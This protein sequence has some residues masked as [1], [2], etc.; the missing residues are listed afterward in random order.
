MS[1]LIDRLEEQA[2]TI[3]GRLRHQ[4]LATP[5]GL[6][7]RDIAFV[8]EQLER[9]KE[10]HHDDMTKLRQIEFY[11]EQ[12]LQRISGYDFHHRE[13]LEDKLFKLDVE[14]CRRMARY[15][16]KLSELHEK[17]FVLFKRHDVLS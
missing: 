5:L 9:V 13:Q 11:N 14:R 10:I 2:R 15:H 1:S 3:R 8:A 17:L 4:E 6:I 12:K 16:D 7:E